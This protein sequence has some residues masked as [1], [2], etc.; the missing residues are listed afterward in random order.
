MTTTTLDRTQNVCDTQFPNGSVF[1]LCGDHSRGDTQ[2]ADV[3][4]DTSRN[5]SPSEP[6]KSLVA[7]DTC[8]NQVISEAQR[9][10][11]AADSCETQAQFDTHYKNGF[12]ESAGSDQASDA[13]PELLRRPGGLTPYLCDP[14]IYMLAAQ[15]DDIED[16]RKAG[17]NRLRILTRSE[18]DK[19]GELRGYALDIHHPTVQALTAIQATIE[20]AE[21]QTVKALEK[22][23]KTNPLY[24]WSKTIKGLG[25]KT[26]ARLLATIG[27][28]Y[29]RVDGTTRTVGQLWSYMGLHVLDMTDGTQCAARNMR[30]IQSNW[31]TIAKTRLYII[32][33]GLLKAGIRKTDSGERYA[34]TES[35]EVYLSRRMRTDETHPEWTDAHRHNDAMRVMGKRFIRDLWCEAKRIHEQDHPNETE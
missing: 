19:D 4:A 6:Q 32:E 31:K 11:V 17:A 13:N 29:V 14:A 18:T 20:Q 30:G 28:P 1:N 23:M 33:T 16:Q 25:A 21:Q 9:N 2:H 35:G 26:F 8:G 10:H 3:S 12:A 22:A 34:I 5:Q 24:E 27:D 15:L 7:G